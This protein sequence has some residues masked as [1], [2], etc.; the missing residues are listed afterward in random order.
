V[1]KDVGRTGRPTDITNLWQQSNRHL[2]L[3]GHRRWP[4]SLLFVDVV[5]DDDD[6]VVDVDVVVRLV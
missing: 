6:V 1:S 3:R 5:D 2:Q 4:S